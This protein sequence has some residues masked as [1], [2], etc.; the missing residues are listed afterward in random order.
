M[1]GLALLYSKVG[2]DVRATYLNGQTLRLQKRILGDEHPDTLQS[3][4]R[5]AIS[6]SNIYGFVGSVFNRGQFK[7]AWMRMMTR[8]VAKR[9]T[10]H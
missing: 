10:G 5:L 9:Y 3:M 7:E 6:Y 1:T 8:K 4:N 2:Q